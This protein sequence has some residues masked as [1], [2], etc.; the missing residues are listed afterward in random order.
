[1]GPLN[2]YRTRKHLER[3]WGALHYGEVRA[4]SAADKER[5]SPM[6]YAPKVGS[7]TTDKR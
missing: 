5:P 6:S 7:V 1:M 3:P 2:P 4:K